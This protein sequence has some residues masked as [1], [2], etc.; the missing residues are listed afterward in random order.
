MMGLLSHTFYGLLSH[1]FYGVFPNTLVLNVK[2][3]IIETT[4]IINFKERE[5]N[6]SLWDFY[7]VHLMVLPRYSF[8]KYQSHHYRHDHH[9]PLRPEKKSIM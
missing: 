6:K 7:H 2:V 8:P 1:T 3:I 9:H 5:K 4:I